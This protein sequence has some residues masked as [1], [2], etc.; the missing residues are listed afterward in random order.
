MYNNIILLQGFIEFL[1]RF[2]RGLIR[3]DINEKIYPFKV[4]EQDVGSSVILDVGVYKDD[5]FQTRADEGFEGNGYDWSSLAQVFL[6]EEMPELSDEIYFDSEAGMFCA[7][8]DDSKSLE[9]FAVAF[10]EATQDDVKIN[11]LFSRAELD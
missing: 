10:F 1:K 7:Y 3:L 6:D 2:K 5:I 4:V 8:S 9:E 11:D